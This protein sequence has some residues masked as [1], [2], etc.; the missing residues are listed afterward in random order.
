MP[1]TAVG[2]VAYRELENNEDAKD[3]KDKKEKNE[4]KR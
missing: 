2:K 4:T 3:K 1:V